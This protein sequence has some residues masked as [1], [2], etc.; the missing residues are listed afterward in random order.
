MEYGAYCGIEG[1]AVP[2]GVLAFDD[3][4]I[5]DIDRWRDT[6]GSYDRYSIA[7]MFASFMG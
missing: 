5:D 3:L 6:T 4:M 7:V 2:V 1:H